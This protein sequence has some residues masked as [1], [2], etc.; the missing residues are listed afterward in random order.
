[1]SGRLTARRRLT[2]G[3]AFALLVVAQIAGTGSYNLGTPQVPGT[4]VPESNPGTTI[5]P[6]PSP[7][8]ASSAAGPTGSDGTAAAPAGVTPSGPGYSFGAAPMPVTS[9]GR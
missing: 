1:M 5:A 6:L 4:R 9:I 8:P 3:V 2:L 7:A